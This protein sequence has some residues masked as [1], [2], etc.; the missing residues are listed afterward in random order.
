MTS[1]TPIQLAASAFKRGRRASV[2]VAGSQTNYWVYGAD[3]PNPVQLILIHGYRGN[4]HGLEAIAGA[5]TNFEVVIPDLPGFGESAV[6]AAEHTVSNYANWL[7]EF[8]TRYPNSSASCGK[9]NRLGMRK[10]LG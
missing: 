2:E 1:P 7:L 4:H 6:L 3:Q 10:L 5:L 9:W 8:A